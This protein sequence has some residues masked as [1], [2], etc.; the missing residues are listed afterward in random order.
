MAGPASGKRVHR[1]LFGAFILALVLGQS[2][3]LAHQHALDHPSSHDCA[4]CLY[5]QHSGDGIPSTP[6]H[7]STTASGF[8]AIAASVDALLCV[9]APA[10]RS[11]APPVALK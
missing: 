8:V 3:A 5:A 4:L 7:F 10:F 2:L 9:T 1:L 6:F 11:R